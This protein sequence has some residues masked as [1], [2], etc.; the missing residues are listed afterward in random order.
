ME[1]LLVEFQTRLGGCV[2]FSSGMTT[3]FDTSDTWKIFNFLNHER[4]KAE[5][6]SVRFLFYYPV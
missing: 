3:V 6:F 2:I 4:F 5:E 1:L